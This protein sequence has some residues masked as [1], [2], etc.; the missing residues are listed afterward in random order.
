MVA[1][2]FVALL[3]LAIYPQLLLAADCLPAA[4]ASPAALAGTGKVDFANLF[5]ITYY[6]TYKV[7]TFASTLA[8]YKS[9]H[10]TKAGQPIPPIV[11]YQC[12]TTKPAFGDPGLDS[13]LVSLETRFFEI[14]IQRASL[15]WGGA[16]PFFEMLGLTEYIQKIDMTYISAPC[17]QLM[18]VCEPGIHMTGGSD[19][20]KAHHQ[21]MT[22]SNGS[23]VFTDSFGTGFSDSSWDVEFMVSVDPGIL[24]RAEWVSFVAAFFN[25]EQQAAQIFSTIRSDYDAMKS[26][27]IQLG[28]DTATEWGGRQPLVAWTD[29]QQETCPSPGTNCGNV[30]WTQVDGSWC[31]CGALYK[32]STAHYKRDMVEDAGGRLVSMPTEAAMPA[33]CTMA[34]NT[35]GSQTLTCDPSGHAA[36]V[37]FLASADV[38]FDESRIQGPDSYDTTNHDF[39]GSYSVTAAE[40]PALARN[41]VNIFRLDGSTSDLRDGTRGSNWFEASKAQPQQLLAGMMEALWG[42]KFKSPC[43]MKY[44][45]RAIPGQG[46]EVLAHADC[47]FYNQGGVH[48]CGA[49]HELQHQIPQCMPTSTSDD[50]ASS[51]SGVGLSIGVVLAALATH[52]SWVHHM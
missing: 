13:N 45:R 42:D 31:H 33:G 36:Y 26:L 18:E 1:Q 40:V 52:G 12:G 8:T 11:L 19:E 51:A 21:A 16:L 28:S 20:F 32:I 41:P 9:Y 5:D 2:R 6:S 17:V 3:A 30:G 34:T 46:Q 27:A 7:I 37:G 14:P 47:Q 25:E 22:P 48:D 44:L 39:A 38:I 43:G 23:V 35:D 29:S 15:S 10:P 49:I 50:E 4:K 24:N